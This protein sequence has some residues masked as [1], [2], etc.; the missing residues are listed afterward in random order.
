ME[1]LPPL[2]PI[3]V[4]LSLSKIMQIVELYNNEF[5]VGDGSIRELL[6]HINE[7]GTE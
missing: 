3:N 4:G 1:T 6:M 7:F 2:P 5:G